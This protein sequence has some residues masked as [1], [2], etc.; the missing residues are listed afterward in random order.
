MNEVKIQ[1]H[2]LLTLGNL[3]KYLLRDQ[4]FASCLLNEVIHFNLC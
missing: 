3:I 2:V 4:A 1:T